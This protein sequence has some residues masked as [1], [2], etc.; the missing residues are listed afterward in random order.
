MANHLTKDAPYSGERSGGKEKEASVSHTEA[1]C[2]CCK[3][4]LQI[5]FDQ[6]LGD[7]HGVERR[8]L[9]EL[10]PHHPEVQ[11]VGNVMRDV[12]MRNAGRNAGRC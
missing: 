11:A 8:S 7:L 6:H 9:A 5:P 3:G 1:S 12:I 4:S 10:V 2:L